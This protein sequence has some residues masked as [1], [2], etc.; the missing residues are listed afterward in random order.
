MAYEPSNPDPKRAKFRREM[1]RVLDTNGW[2]EI[3]DYNVEVSK[4]NGFEGKV[5]VNRKEDGN[6]C[7]SGYRTSGSQ[8]VGTI[9]V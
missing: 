8:G 1:K 9:F 7:L 4:I 2:S 5:F 6:D 3:K